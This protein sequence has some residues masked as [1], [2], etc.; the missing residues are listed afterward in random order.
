M[1]IGISYLQTPRYKN[2]FVII[3][4]STRNFDEYRIGHRYTSVGAALHTILGQFT[5]H[6]HKTTNF[7]DSNHYV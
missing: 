1:F 2:F 4:I 6:V 5:V 3:F 7:F